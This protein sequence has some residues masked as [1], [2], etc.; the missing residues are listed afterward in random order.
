MCL[1]VTI[2]IVNVLYVCLFVCLFVC[3]LNLF[4]LGCRFSVVYRKYIV[5]AGLCSSFFMESFICFHL[6]FVTFPLPPPPPSNN[7]HIEQWKCWN[8]FIVVEICGD[9]FVCYISCPKVLRFN[10]ASLTCACIGCSVLP[11]GASERALLKLF[12]L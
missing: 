7:Y 8:T 6:V 9:W 1:V 11:S 10:Q 3:L 4:S 12:K 5:Y 2:A